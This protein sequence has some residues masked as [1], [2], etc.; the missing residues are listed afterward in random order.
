MRFTASELRVLFA[1]K[2]VCPQRCPVKSLHAVT[3]NI[4]VDGVQMLV[5]KVD[6]LDV[7]IDSLEAKVDGVA[8]DLTVHRTDTEAH[9][10][11]YRVKEG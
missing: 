6:R 10:G 3:Q 4:V 8:L 2:S 1:L 7:R 11:M 9:H 5:E